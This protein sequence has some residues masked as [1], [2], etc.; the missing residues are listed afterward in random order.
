MWICFKGT[1]KRFLML[2]GKR[3][4]LKDDFK[5]STLATV[6]RMDQVEQDG[7]EDQEFSLGSIEFKKSVRY[8]SKDVEKALGY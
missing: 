5:V 2:L 3:R 6:S 8:T 7:K 4:D 1:A